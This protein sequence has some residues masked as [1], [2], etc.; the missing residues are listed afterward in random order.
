MSAILNSVGTG[1]SLIEEWERGWRGSDKF[2]CLGCIGDDYLEGVVAR[3]L[4]DS[5]ACSFCGAEPAAGFDAFME[6]FMVGVDNTFEQADNAGMLWDGS[7]VFTTYEHYELPDSFD[8]VAAGE[9]EAEVFDEIRSRLIEKT[10]ASRWWGETEPH[11]AYS[12]AWR[13]FREQILHRTR[14]VFWASENP[15]ELYIDAGDVPVA[16]VLEVIGQLLIEFDLVTTL[17]A[18]TAAYR[19]RGH[20]Q[21]TDSREWSAA[22]LGTNLPK[23]ATSASRMS[24]AGI[25]L[26]YGGDDVDTSLAEAARANDREFFTVGKF[27]TTE[28]VAV[29]DLTHVP[30][31]PSIFDPKLGAHQGQLRFL[32]ALVDELR[33]PIDTARSNLDYVPTQVFCEYFLNVFDPEA[34][35]GPLGDNDAEAEFDSKAKIRGL[36]WMSAAAAGGGC[37]ALNVSQEDCVDVADGTDGRL[38]LHLVP[39][40]ITVHRRRTDEFRQVAGPK[41]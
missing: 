14:F 2:I 26:F 30:A 33:Q 5:E 3:A 40:S 35:A 13:A 23:N 7:Y 29:I 37:L 16:K 28:P 15:G 25:P 36:L 34:Q 8:W 31:V 12:S 32:N 27:V 21:Y 24:P 41:D 9:H 19:A 17:P 1:N 20:A 10:Y 11:E 6:A 38:R 39:G 4:V 18:G 22:Q